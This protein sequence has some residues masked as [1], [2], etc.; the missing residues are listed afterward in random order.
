MKIAF[1][2]TKPYDRTWFEPLSKEYGHQIL[3][4]QGLLTMDTIPLAQGCGAVCVFVN[5]KVDSELIDTLHQ[6]GVQ[7]ILLRSAG[8]NHV[9]IQAAK[10]KL[11]VLRVP[12][13]SPSA[14]AEF[15]AALL[16]TLNRKTHKAYNRTRDFN[17]TING[18]SGMDLKGKTAGIIGTGQIGQ[19]MIQILKGFGMKILGYDVY[20]NADL[21]IEY[22]DLD[23]LIQQSDVISLHCPLT[24]DTYHIIDDKKMEKMKAGVYLINTSRGALIDSFALLHAL[25][26]HQIF[27]GVGLDVYEEEDGVFYEDFSDRI[28]KDDILARLITFPNVLITSHQGFFTQDALEAIARTTLENASAVENGNSLINEVL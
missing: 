28:V 17:M 22:T 26:N 13:Y 9:D 25:R 21:G 27:G 1:F 11:H 14:V 24:K 15:A 4:I 8:F 2:G 16:L 19:A 6:M 20:P 18:L 12:N 7:A 10:G 5:D 23:T 3:F